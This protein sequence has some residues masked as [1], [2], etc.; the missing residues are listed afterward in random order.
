M[1]HR[2]SLIAILALAPVAHA[3]EVT[4]AAVVAKA[5]DEIW[6]L[7]Q[8]IYQGRAKAGLSFYL[9]NA[10]PNYMG[11]PPQA[12]KPM[13]LGALKTSAPELTANNKEKLT[14]ALSGFTLQGDTGVIYYNTHRTMRADGTPVDERFEV[15]HVW[16]RSGGKWTIIGA[17]ARAEPKRGG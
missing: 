8:S 5:R 6:A 12:A 10:S 17:M 7:E 4:P 16:L 2:L 13:D 15:I 9:D 14:M 3:A 11:W 1:N